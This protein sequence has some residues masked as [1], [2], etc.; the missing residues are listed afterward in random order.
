MPHTRRSARN[1]ALRTLKAARRRLRTLN[2][3]SRP[4]TRPEQAERA[5]LESLITTSLE[6]AARLLTNQE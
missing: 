1:E 3:L 2:S 5:D 6:R 4:L